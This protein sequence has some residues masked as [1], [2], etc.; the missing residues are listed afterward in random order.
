MRA[1]ALYSRV[2]GII[3][4]FMALISIIHAAVVIG[5]WCRHKAAI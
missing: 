3:V 4:A 5:L 2:G 1:R